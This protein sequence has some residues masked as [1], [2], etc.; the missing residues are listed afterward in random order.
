L[1]L[2]LSNRVGIA[3]AREVAKRI[4]AADVLK[5]DHDGSAQNSLAG[6]G[7]KEFGEDALNRYRAPHARK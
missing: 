2:I 5:S 6:A 1:R 7:T 3:G 4:S